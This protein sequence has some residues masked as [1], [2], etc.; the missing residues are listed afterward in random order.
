MFKKLKLAYAVLASS[1]VFAP[2]AVIPFA[3]LI[4]LGAYRYHKESYMGAR[5]L[6]MVAVCYIIVTVAVYIALGWQPTIWQILPK[7]FLIFSLHRAAFN[8]HRIISRRSNISFARDAHQYMVKHGEHELV[9][10]ALTRK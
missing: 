7:L 1:V 8:F 2:L 4:K 5:Y 9:K 10:S 3:M 6:Q